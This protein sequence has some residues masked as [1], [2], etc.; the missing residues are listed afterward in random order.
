MNVSRSTFVKRGCV[1]TA[2]TLA[3]LLTG[4]SATAWAQSSLNVGLSMRASPSTTLEEGASMD[5]STPGRITLTIIRSGA[6]TYD[7]DRTVA[8]NDRTA[9]FVPGDASHVRLKATCNGEG[10]TSAPA[11]TA[12]SFGVAVKSGA[13]AATFGAE[14]GGAGTTLNFSDVDGDGNVDKTIEL[15]VS[16]TADNGD[17]D[18]ETIGLTLE[19]AKPSVSVTESD[20]QGGTRTSTVSLRASPRNLTMRVADDEQSPKLS[21]SSPGIQ[22]AMGNKQ[23]TTVGV[24]IRNRNPGGAAMRTTLDGLD[25]AGED[26]I[27][28]SVSPQEAVGSIIKIY[29]GDTAPPGGTNLDVDRDGNY[30]VGTIGGGSA[31]GGAVGDSSADDGIDLTI[32]AINVSG[33]RD[34][35]ITLTLM[36]GRTEAQ[37]M[38]DGGAIDDSDPATVTVLSGEE[39]PTVAF[40]TDSVTIDEGG[41]EMVH[42]L[43]DGDQGDQVGSATVS[44]SG[45][46]LISLRQGNSAISGGVVS[47]GDSANAELTIVALSDRELEDGEEKTATVRITDASG[48]NLGDQRELMV[49]VVGSTAVPVLPLVGQLLLAL[50][51]TAGGAR[52]YRRR[53]Q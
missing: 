45:D 49:T 1:L 12:C 47:F 35:Q 24:D 53:Q 5:P 38:G 16:D 31:A 41:M 4:F 33:F 7:S 8:G 52:L 50:L 2:L 42:L 15:Y 9:V 26:D 36:D 25:T 17:W 23:P 3:V 44:V 34:E 46:A 43:A 51:L 11:D 13:V 10:F 48:A 20:G 37:K 18:E 19:L 32:E 40:S 27:L 28:L 21:F 6:D 14:L 39:T 29:S 30:V 22:L